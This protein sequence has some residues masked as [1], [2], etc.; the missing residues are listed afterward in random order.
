MSDLSQKVTI[1]NK[2][3]DVDIYRGDH[4]GWILEVIDELGTST[5]WDD[6]FDTDQTAL[7]EALVSIKRGDIEEGSGKVFPFRHKPKD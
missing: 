6:E 3:Y 5:I 2:D 7:D 1:Q 4:G